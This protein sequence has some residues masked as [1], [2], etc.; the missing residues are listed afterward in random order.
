LGNDTILCE[1]SVQTLN[2]ANSNATYKWNDLSSNASFPVSKPG[3]FSVE[4][5]MNGCIKRDTI[6][7]R[8]LYKPV[9]SLGN[10]T[11]LCTG[12]QL[13]LNPKISN[14]T[15]QWQDGSTA[16]TYKVLAAGAYKLTATNTCGSTSDAIMVIKSMCKLVMPNAFTPNNDGINN[17]FRVKYPEFI[18]T[19]KM[20]IFNRWG[21]II[22]YSEN[23]RMGWDGNYKQKKLEA[24]N[25][26]WQISLTDL[27]GNTETGQGTVLLIR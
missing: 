25:Y 24:G 6:N 22:F 9:F 17:V 26:I 2:A 10:D 15:Y 21:Q 20:K 19:F 5:N 14:V 4:V 8:Y 7:I 3:S 1:G 18:K 27:E 12:Q 23:P 16:P 11:L 13:L